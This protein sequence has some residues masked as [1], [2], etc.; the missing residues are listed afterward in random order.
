M[1]AQGL[2]KVLGELAD[3]H[4]EMVK[5]AQEKQKCVIENRVDQLMTITAKETRAISVLERLGGELQSAAVECWKELGMAPKPNSTLSDLMQAITRTD[6]KR[7][8]SQA[9]ERLSG[10]IRQLKEIN[11]RNQQLVRQSLDW[12]AFQ[13]DLFTAPY[14]DVTYSAP[15]AGGYRT[16]IRSFDT[17]A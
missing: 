8:L 10:A 14:D 2:L 11:E 7:D 6:L 13:I 12:I 1:S 16:P 4:D 9:A 5:L 15:Q 17:R 3:F